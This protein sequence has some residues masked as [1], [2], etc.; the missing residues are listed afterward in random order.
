M[1]KRILSIMLLVVMA[2]CFSVTAFATAEAADITSEAGTDSGST[3]YM[4]EEEALE[5]LFAQAKNATNQVYRILYARG[6][7]EFVKVFEYIPNGG[8]F[9]NKYTDEFIFT[10]EKNSGGGAGRYRKGE[11]GGGGRE[12]TV[13]S[14]TDVPM[15]TD[16]FKKILL[17]L[18][19]QYAPAETV[20][21][22]SMQKSSNKLLNDKTTASLYFPF[23][24]GGEIWGHEITKPVY[25]N[26][27]YV[28]ENGSLWI[29]EQQSAFY[30]AIDETDSKVYFY[31]DTFTTDLISSERTY[32]YQKKQMREYASTDYYYLRHGSDFIFKLFRCAN[33]ADYLNISTVGG[34]FTFGAD[35][36][37]ISS[38]DA[39]T[40]ST[41][42]IYSEFTGVP[43][44]T[45]SEYLPLDWGFYIS[46]E[47]I[48]FEGMYKDMDPEKFDPNGVITP[49]GDDIY[50]WTITNNDGDTNTINEYITNNYVYITNNY[51]DD[52]D[53]GDG[54]NGGDGGDSSANVTVGDTNVNVGGDDIDININVDTDTS[55]PT[56]PIEVNF[57]NYLEV[58][59]EYAKPLVVFF[60]GFFEFV[61]VEIFN[62]I[63]AGV[64]VSIILRI[65][66]R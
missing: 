37:Y 54:G 59:P 33:A 28:D 27:Y 14:F 60:Q 22:V 35:N 58:L 65:W 39:S 62:L 29:N 32:Q 43:Y 17:Q 53:D 13:N 46:D 45:R 42:R 56:M 31:Y 57:D 15:G 30:A 4:T 5:W 44:N 2:F 34:G 26:I 9:Y 50:N 19:S 10:P 6:R 49:T 20:D 3:T 47:P 36:K 52:T 8:Y 48:V 41:I 51:G 64:A 63:C 25:V 21:F 40:S 12:R 11:G 66:G 38:D 7:E 16:L 1:K 24:E 18:Q 61:P 55:E 23:L